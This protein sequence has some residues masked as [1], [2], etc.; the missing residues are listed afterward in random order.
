MKL[1][2]K[3]QGEGQP[4]IF[5]HGVFGSLDNLNMLAKDFVSNY[6]TI[7]VDLR[8]HGHSPWSDKMN[9]QVMAEDVAELCDALK[10]KDVILIGHSMGGKVA[11]QLSQVFPTIIQK[12]GII[13]IAPIKYARSPNAII[14]RALMYCLS[15]KIT[16]KKQIINVMKQAG[17]NDAVILFLL[18]SFKDQHWLFNIEAINNQYSH[19]CDWQSISPCL[20]PTLFI[21]G[22][23]SPY[24]ADEYYEAISA[25]FPLS[26]IE[27]VDGAGHNVHA[28]KTGE[29]LQLLHHWLEYNS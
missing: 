13:D 27:V 24:V 20:I 12:L 18:K 29:V 10:L 16:D 9:Y 21:R 22:G 28:E 26:K 14:L 11:L 7:Q 25:Q 1:N 4:I 6:Q 19:I 17:I 23:N 5:M 2:Y 8:N 3:L 15:N